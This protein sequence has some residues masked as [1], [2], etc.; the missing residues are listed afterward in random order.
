MGSNEKGCT[1]C[2][3]VR[4]KNGKYCRDCWRAIGKRYNP[5][6]IS[7]LGMMNITVTQKR[8]CASC[9][10]LPKCIEVDNVRDGCDTVFKSLQDRK[11]KEMIRSLAGRVSG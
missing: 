6:A 5:H 9:R 2:N 10:I 3:S 11:A 4:D 8:K 7:I 1:L